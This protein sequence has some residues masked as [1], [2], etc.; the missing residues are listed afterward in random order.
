MLLDRLFPV[1]HSSWGMNP[2]LTPV[3]NEGRAILNLAF[4]LSG[5]LK[6]AALAIILQGH[7]LETP[8]CGLYCR[9]TFSSSTWPF[10]FP[11][12]PLLSKRPSESLPQK[13]LSSW[14]PQSP[15]PASVGRWCSLRRRGC[16]SVASGLNPG[17]LQRHGG[18]SGLLRTLDSVQWD[19]KPRLPGLTKQLVRR[20][21]QADSTLESSSCE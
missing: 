14:P 5:P 11:F 7:S 17:A 13:T 8:T 21:W 9:K 15:S 10:F 1:A 6:S 2:V 18:V 20:E 12:L 3:R 16:C 19:P 4:P